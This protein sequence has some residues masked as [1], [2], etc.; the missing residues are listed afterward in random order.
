MVNGQLAGR[1]SWGVSCVCGREVRMRLGDTGQKLA[2][3]VSSS[4][5]VAAPRFH[6]SLVTSLYE[7]WGVQGVFRSFSG[8]AIHVWEGTQPLGF[9]VLLDRTGNKILYRPTDLH[10]TGWHNLAVSQHVPNMGALFPQTGQIETW[11][12]HSQQL[13]LPLQSPDGHGRPAQVRKDGVS[14]IVR[15][16]LGARL[17]TLPAEI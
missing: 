8:N 4:G 12:H 6:V 13:R 3:C 16:A 15:L 2:G 10:C 9:R 7:C 14:A 5:L 1:S 11:S 17:G